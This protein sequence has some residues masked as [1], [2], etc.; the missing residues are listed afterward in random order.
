MGG[1][2]YSLS[3]TNGDIFET[4]PFP[5]NLLKKG[6]AH[7][8]EIGRLL[9]DE[10]QA[11]MQERGIGLTA[12]YNRFH[13]SS[14]QDEAI[15]RL[16]QRQSEVNA[17]V[18]ERYGWTDIDPMTGFHQ[19]GYLPE[20]N[21]TRYTISEVARVEVLRRLAKLNKQKAGS[22]AEP[23]TRDPADDDIEELAEGL[24]APREARRGTD[25]G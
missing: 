23:V 18:L 20:G 8:E 16:R 19:V 4:F 3:Y 24:F 21:N 11:F 15:G 12:F 6:D 1:D 5:E 7:L 14:M 13:D 22:Q 25:S 10:R 2:L 9:F 17:A